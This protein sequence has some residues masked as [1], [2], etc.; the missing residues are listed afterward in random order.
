MSHYV[1]QTVKAVYALI[2]N[3]TPN[4]AVVALAHR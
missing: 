1:A 2:L 4:Y 3:R